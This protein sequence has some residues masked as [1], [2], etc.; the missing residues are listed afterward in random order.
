MEE[1]KTTYVLYLYN[2]GILKNFQVRQ[3]E[4]NTIIPK[5]TQ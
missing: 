2:G 5:E 3:K 1:N 4:N